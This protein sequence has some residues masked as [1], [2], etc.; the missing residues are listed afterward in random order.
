MIT[1][2]GW[3]GVAFSGES[4][5][6]LRASL[7]SRIAV[8][9]SLG[10]PTGWATANQVHGNAVVEVF[11]SGPAGDADAM[12]TMV[13]G[14]P[15]VVFTADCLGVVVHGERAVG[16]AHAGWRGAATG[17]VSSLCEAMAGA[18]HNPIRI[19]VGPGIGPCCFEVGDEVA[20]RFGQA[21]SQTTWNTTSVDLV[22]FVREQL[23]EV[24]IWVA[25]VCTMHEP[26]WFSHR[27]NGTESRMGALGWI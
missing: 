25:D 5:G 23:P 12:W 22:R 18:G 21:V 17:V 7:K 13:A 8:S 11:D 14:L 16:V 19:A 1:P 6:D 3:A 9:E 10:I 2:P 20:S 4:E 27:E 24:D 15:L 26:G